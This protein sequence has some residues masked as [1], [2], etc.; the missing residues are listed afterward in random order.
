MIA[1]RWS[2]ARAES[3]VDHRP[4]LRR[5]VSNVG[6]L[7]FERVAPML[8]AFIVNAL[9]V[10]YLGPA[11]Y[12]LLGYAL[13]FGAMFATLSTFGGDAVIV[14]ELTRTPERSGEILGTALVL[15]LVAGAL[16]WAAAVVAVRHLNDDPL[17]R[18]LVVIMTAQALATAP[19]VFE[20]WFRARI[21]AR[22]MVIARTGAVLTNQAGRVALVLTGAALPAFAGLTVGTA[23]LGAVAV[24]ALYA[25]GSG[26]ALRFRWEQAR[27]LLRDSWPLAIVNISIIVYMKIDQVMLTDIAGPRENGIYATAV[28]LSELWFFLPVAIGN[29]VFPLIVTAHDNDDRRQFDRKLQLFLDAM[30]ALGYAVAIPVFV[31]ATPI[32]RIVYG[33]EFAEAAGVLRIHVVSFVFVCMG[34]ARGV[35]LVTKNY[36]RFNMASSIAAAVLNVVLNLVLIPRHGAMG[37]AWST[38]IS[39]AV[40]NYFSGLLTTKLW[41]ET[42]ML[43][44]SLAVPFRV[45]RIARELSR[46]G[47]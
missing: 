25:R 26:D 4:V 16:V 36:V 14:R 33:A 41:K 32:V 5:I 47:E 40:A 30:T 18:L 24:Y 19:A 37:A 3:A 45:V 39:Y 8:T 12:G 23:L 15:R 9:V 38:L 22:E 42:W 11:Q 7:V 21:A 46:S 35:Y 29:T 6:W 43:T 13:S 20:C 2:P 44:R 28:A 27:S 34:I 31:F 10:R 1:F 17:T